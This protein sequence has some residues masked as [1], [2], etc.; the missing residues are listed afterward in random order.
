MKM[1]IRKL[2]I[3]R[4]ITLLG[5]VLIATTTEADEPAGGIIGQSIKQC[6]GAWN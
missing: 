4:A 6:H 1:N 3:C 5:V 2:A